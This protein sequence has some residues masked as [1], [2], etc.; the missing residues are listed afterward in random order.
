MCGMVVDGV[1]VDVERSDCVMQHATNVVST[2]AGEW[3]TDNGVL[4]D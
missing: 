4:A 1:L 3:M 2:I